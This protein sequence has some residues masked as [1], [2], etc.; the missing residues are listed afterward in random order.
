MAVDARLIFGNFG[1][2][3][4]ELEQ[5]A[6][7]VRSSDGGILEY[8][9]TN[10]GQA[11][12]QSDLSPIEYLRYR[13]FETE[14]LELDEDA[15]EAALDLRNWKGD[16]SV[17]ASFG[18][19]LSSFAKFLIALFER[20]RLPVYPLLILHARNFE[21]LSQLEGRPEFLGLYEKVAGVHWMLAK[22]AETFLHAVE[23]WHKVLSRTKILHVAAEGPVDSHYFE[24]WLG[25][26]GLGNIK[27]LS[28]RPRNSP[29]DLALLFEHHSSLVGFVALFLSTK[30]KIR[31]AKV[32]QL[33]GVGQQESSSNNEIDIFAISMGLASS[34]NSDYQLSIKTLLPKHFLLDLQLG[35]KVAV[36][37]K[38]RK[39]L[40]DLLSTEQE[41]IH[42]H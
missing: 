21:A 42:R 18:A 22:Q 7:V 32:P 30:T 10:L 31:L 1:L 14:D 35:M 13:N 9:W 38:A 26:T 16:V 25:E 39:I 23:E 40:V 28:V 20:D 2:L 12:S 24:S 11:A 41:G 4:S 37:Q 36:F 34:Q 19:Q 6:L 8:D 3:S 27:V 5:C 29:V 17:Q 15:L 33:T